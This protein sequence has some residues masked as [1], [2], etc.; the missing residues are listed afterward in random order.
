MGGANLTVTVTRVLAL[1]HTGTAAL[2][3]TRQVAVEL[4]IA[5][6]SGATYDSTASGDVSVVPSAGQAE[7]LDVRTGPCTT[8]LVDFESHVYSGS[9]RDGCVAFSLPRHARVLAV[10]FS[11]Q[12]RARGTL[13]WRVRR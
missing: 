10:R 13:T 4:R 2:P 6:Q 12:S 1:A 7:P 8:Q 9:V 3:G 5:N 11:P